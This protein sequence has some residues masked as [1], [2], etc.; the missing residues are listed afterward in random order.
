VR[1][2]HLC[3]DYPC[4]NCSENVPQAIFLI[5]F[6]HTQTELVFSCSEKNG[7]NFMCCSWTFV[8]HA[9]FHI[10]CVATPLQCAWNTRTIP[11]MVL[12]Q[13]QGTSIT[14][15][16]MQM[17]KHHGHAQRI[18][19][20]PRQSWPSICPY[21]RTAVPSVCLQ[22]ATNGHCCMLRSKITEI[23]AQP[24]LKYVFNDTPSYTIICKQ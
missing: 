8:K 5:S 3:T 7:V 17:L 24:N 16:C 15:L 1:V 22:Q 4:S 21:S 23:H 2:A 20:H 10:S 6:L 9:Q 11:T 18:I 14:L 12:V 13:H 19:P